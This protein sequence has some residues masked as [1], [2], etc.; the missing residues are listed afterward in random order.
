MLYVSS[1]SASSGEV[2]DRRRG[3]KKKDG[4]RF[5]VFLRERTAERGMKMK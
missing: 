4:Q 2:D 3:D 5:F 1:V